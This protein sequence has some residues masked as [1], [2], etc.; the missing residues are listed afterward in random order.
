MT[1][2]PGL[3]VAGQAADDTVSN[4]IEAV[5]Q[6]Q[7]GKGQKRKRLGRDR[8]EDEG[9]GEEQQEDEPPVQEVDS[10]QRGESSEKNSA[11]GWL[12]Q[13]EVQHLHR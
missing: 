3:G 9:E 1:P 12:P 4:V 13:E 8:D 10:E 2:P 7:R 6:G 5:A 11:E